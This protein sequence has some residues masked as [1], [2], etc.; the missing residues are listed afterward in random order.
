MALVLQERFFEGTAESCFIDDIP[1][2]GGRLVEFE[3]DLFVEPI[4]DEF[5]D[6]GIVGNIPSYLTRAPRRFRQPSSKRTELGPGTGTSIAWTRS[7][8]TTCAC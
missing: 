3:E 6:C 2:C 4:D 5:R 7:C 8:S 1:H